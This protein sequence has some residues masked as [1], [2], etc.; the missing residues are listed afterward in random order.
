[1]NCCPC[2]G[3]PYNYPPM[4]GPPGYHNMQAWPTTWG[5]TTFW[6]APPPPNRYVRAGRETEAALARYPSGWSEPASE[7][8]KIP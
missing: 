2:C 1:M 3:R 7:W 8:D 5:P 4:P 6:P